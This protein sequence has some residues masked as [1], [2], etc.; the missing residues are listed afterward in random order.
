[1]RLFEMSVIELKEL[2]RNLLVAR[3]KRGRAYRLRWV[4]IID[5]WIRKR[6]RG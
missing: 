3:S 5:M 4:K 1:M 2:R 6:Q